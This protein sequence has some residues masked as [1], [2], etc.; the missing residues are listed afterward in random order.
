MDRQEIENRWEKWRNQREY[1]KNHT[2]DNNQAPEYD[3]IKEMIGKFDRDAAQERMSKKP[4]P[5]PQDR[6]I[7][8][9]FAKEIESNVCPICLQ[10]LVPPMHSPYILFP[11]GHTFCQTC[12][13]VYHKKTNKKICALCK[14]KYKSRAKN[15]ALQSLIELYWA[16]KDSIQQQADQEQ[17]QNQQNVQEQDS[18]NALMSNSAQDHYKKKLKEIQKRIAVMEEQNSD[19]M[20]KIV[21]NRRKVKVETETIEIFNDQITKIEKKLKTLQEEQELAQQFRAKS[22]NKVKILTHFCKIV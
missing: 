9:T 20:N 16:K 7:E 14:Q 21:D 11:C 18:I 22:E 5:S 17:L 15:I 10:L 3:I 1:M 12:I 8:A 13:E 19:L 2:D 6:K 4:E